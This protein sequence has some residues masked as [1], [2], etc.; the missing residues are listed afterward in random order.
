MVV[1]EKVGAKNKI[2]WCIYGGRQLMLRLYTALP[3]LRTAMSLSFIFV[4]KN[5]RRVAGGL[6]A[7]AVNR[8]ANFV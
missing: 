8:L 5:T 6:C 1:A 3:A 2:W 7:V 4:W